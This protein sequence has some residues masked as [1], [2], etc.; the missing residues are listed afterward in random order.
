MLRWS[1]KTVL[2]T[3]VY[4]FRGLPREVSA[5]CQF[6]ISIYS[7]LISRVLIATVKNRGKCPCPRCLIPKERFC[8]LGLPQDLRKR[9]TLAR[10]DNYSRQAKVDSARRLIHEKHY[11]LDGKAVNA[12]LQTQS[13]VPTQVSSLNIRLYTQLIFGLER[14][15]VPL[16]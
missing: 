7:P 2:S 1:D 3:F 15:F 5:L 10:V 8:N 11:A 13:L 4:L 16:G 14:I 6:S 9:S 12:L